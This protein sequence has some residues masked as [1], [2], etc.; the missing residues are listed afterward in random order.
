MDMTATGRNIVSRLMLPFM[1]R[2]IQKAIESDMLAVKLW[3]EA[4]SGADTAS[5]G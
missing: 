1:K 5:G 4:N 2:P 3:C